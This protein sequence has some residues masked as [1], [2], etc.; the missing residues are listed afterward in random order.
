MRLLLLL[1]LLASGCTPRPDASGGSADASGEDAVVGTVTSVDLSPMAYDGDAIIEMVTDSGDTLDVH[2]AA[3]MN[4]CEATGLSTVGSLQSGDRIEVVGE[5]GEDGTLRPCSSAEHRLMREGFST[6]TY[7]G[8]Y[9]S[10]FETSGFK[11]CDAY[12]EDWWVRGTD[13]LSIRYQ[14][15]ADEEGGTPGRGLGPFVRLVVEGERSE[16]G[17]HGHLGGYDRELVV[18]RVIS[19]EYLAAGDGVWPEI[20]CSE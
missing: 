13:D 1:A 15:I 2:I 5:R 10:G 9:A 8:A 12:D 19:M 6:G 14:T 16:R 11:P 7:E 4:L 17:E 3:R 20:A 18:T